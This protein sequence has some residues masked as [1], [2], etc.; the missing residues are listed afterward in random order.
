[1]RWPLCVLLGSATATASP[2]DLDGLHVDPARVV[3]TVERSGATLVARVTFDDGGGRLRGPRVLE[4]G[5]CSDVLDAIALVIAMSQPAAPAV[6]TDN[7]LAVRATVTSRPV[8]D[9]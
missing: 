7:T 4:A 1:M 3:I 5:S 9:L 6:Q 2:C 8:N